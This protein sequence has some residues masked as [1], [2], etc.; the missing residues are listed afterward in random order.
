MTSTLVD[1]WHKQYTSTLPT[2]NNSIIS[3]T[4]NTIETAL[5][6]NL[7]ENASTSL[8]DNILLSPFGSP[9]YTCTSKSTLSD[10][11]PSDILSKIN[12][13]KSFESVYLPLNNIQTLDEV[14][15]TLNKY[16]SQTKEA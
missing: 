6:L 7:G 11:A 3:L 14:V 1:L 8:I 4:L 15:T 2:S 12:R 9:T 13:Y 10:I 5:R 16:V